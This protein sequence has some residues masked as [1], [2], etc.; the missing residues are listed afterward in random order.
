MGSQANKLRLVTRGVVLA[1]LLIGL[2]ALVEKGPPPL[3]I[4]TG[5]TP[6]NPG[7]LGTYTLFTLVKGKYPETTTIF[8]IDELASLLDADRCLYIVISPEKPYSEEEAKKV[9]RILTSKCRRP[10]LLVADEATTSNALLVAAGVSAR[11]A[12]R[13]VVDPL[14]KSPYPK[15]VFLVDGKRFIVTLDIASAVLGGEEVLGAVPLGIVYGESPVPKPVPVAVREVVENLTMIVLGDG[16][17]FLNQVLGSPNSTSYRE[18]AM[19]IIDTL[20]RGDPQCYVIFD[21]SHYTGIPVSQALK[22]FDKLLTHVTPYDIFWLIPLVIAQ[23]IHP[24]T[25]LPPLI[26]A[27]NGAI[28]TVLSHPLGS[29]LVMFTFLTASYYAVERVFPRVRDYRLAEQVEKEVFAT[30][31]IR[32][33]ILAGRYRLTRNDFAR[34]YE[35]VDSVLRTVEGYGL[36]DQRAAELVSKLLGPEKGRRYLESMRKLYEKAVGKRRFLPIV[37]SWHRTTRKMLME[38]EELLQALG[39]SLTAEKGVEYVLMR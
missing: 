28:N 14:T 19:T 17:V 38:S 20:C 34:L 32:S 13:V 23:L 4:F 24:A 5:A 37:L 25:W 3:Y 11:V 8:N 12:G 35:I 22:N 31:D 29:V 1:L 39:S 18:L 33:T 2:L 9:L 16:S 21:S 26:E 36:G 15:A 27:V 30:G 6:A 10:S 7:A